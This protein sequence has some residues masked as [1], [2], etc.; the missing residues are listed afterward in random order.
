MAWFPSQ[1]L[2]DL[3]FFFSSVDLRGIVCLRE[4]VL[5]TVH[6]GTRPPSGAGQGFRV[7]SAFLN[8]IPGPALQ[9]GSGSLGKEADLSCDA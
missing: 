9:P 7:V 2:G 1:D 3:I 6:G 4:T 5:D 8:Q